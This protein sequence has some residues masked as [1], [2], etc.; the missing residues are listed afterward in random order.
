MRSLG[1][2]TGTTTDLVFTDAPSTAWYAESAAAAQQAGLVQGFADGTFRPNA[3]VTREQMVS[4]IARAMHF[5]GKS[6]SSDLSALNRFSDRMDLS[7]WSEEPAALL[8]N[9]HIITGITAA[10]FVPKG[11]ATRAQCAVILR[12]MLQ[13]LEFIN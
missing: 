12:R 13:H 5:A 6:S 2:T 9:S 1:L 8:L 4:M 3:P 7:A 11:L 10:S